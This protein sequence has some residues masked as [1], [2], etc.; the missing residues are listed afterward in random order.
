MSRVKGGPRTARRHR[1][2]L[3][4][5]EGYNQGR[6]RLFRRANEAVTMARAHAYRD[7]R[8]KKRD[9]RRLWVQRI[10]A[11]ARQHGLS[12]SRF[13]N[14][15]RVAGVGIDRKMLADIAVRDPEGFQAIAQI[16]A[17]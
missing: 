3:K 17:E 11:A 16:A 5:A 9:F 6:R 10:N 1:K 4:A 7:R 15:L 12:Y 14:G 8:R 2:I 13:M